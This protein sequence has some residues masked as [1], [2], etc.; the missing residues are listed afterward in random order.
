M[1]SPD[2]FPSSKCIIKVNTLG[3]K[4]S[5]KAFIALDKVCCSPYFF[6]R[7]YIKVSFRLDVCMIK[8]TRHDMDGGP[9]VI[10]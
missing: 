6:P 4:V 3:K 5:K 1:I 10:R 8:G 7:R 2:F 9:G